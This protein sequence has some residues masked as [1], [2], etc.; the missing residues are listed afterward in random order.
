[1]GRGRFPG[2]HK[3]ALTIKGK[4]DKLDFIKIKNFCSSKDIIKAGGRGGMCD[5]GLRG[6]QKKPLKP[7]KPAKDKAFNRNRGKTEKTR[8]A[9]SKGRE[10]RSPSHMEN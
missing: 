10:E 9:K 6:G 2:T 5:V 4:M 1:M 7:K 8:E 3:Q